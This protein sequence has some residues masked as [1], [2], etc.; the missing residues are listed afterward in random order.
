MGF[1]LNDVQ[2]DESETFWQAQGMGIED[3]K[4][5]LLQLPPPQPPSMMALENSNR[6]SQ[7]ALQNGNDNRQMAL[8]NGGQ[9]ALQNGQAS[10]QDRE[11]E[12]ALALPG[13][14]R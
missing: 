6:N 9:A 10:L 4:N 11:Q 5:G 1:D 12:M 8:Q 3:T 7:M 14:L 2:D 13:S